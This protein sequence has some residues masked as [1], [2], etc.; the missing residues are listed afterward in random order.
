MA[1]INPVALGYELAILVGLAC[2]GLLLVAAIVLWLSARRWGLARWGHASCVPVLV[3]TP[4]ACVW[5]AYQCW[6]LHPYIRSKDDD[7][8]AVTKLAADRAS[9]RPTVLA[10]LGLCLATLAGGWAAA[11]SGLGPKAVAASHGG[12]V[13]N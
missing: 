5:V 4:I 1:D 9:L 2:Q 11:R 3:L 8:V 6:Q 10:S 13:P 12:A 7:P